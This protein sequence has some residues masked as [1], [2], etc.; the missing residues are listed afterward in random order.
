[1]VQPYS[2]DHQIREKGKKYVSCVGMTRWQGE[3]ELESVLGLL[4]SRHQPL[5]RAVST[6]LDVSVG[7]VSKQPSMKAFDHVYPP[8]HE[9]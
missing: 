9:T 1:M 7:V 8:K 3:G 4:V 6:Y 2:G 5:A